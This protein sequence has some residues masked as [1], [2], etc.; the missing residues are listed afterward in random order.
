VVKRAARVPRCRF[1]TGAFVLLALSTLP[2]VAAADEP[3]R[4]GKPALLRGR[5]TRHAEGVEGA[6]VHVYRSFD[7][8]LSHSP[9]AASAPTDGDGNYS[10]QL[11]AGTCYLVAK[12]GGGGKDGPLPAGG[13]YSFH[14]SN[15][16]TLAAGE[17]RAAD[18]SLARKGS[19]AVV[20]GSDDPGSGTLAGKV[21]YRGEGMAGVLVRLYL[22]GGSDFRGMGYAAAPP[23]GEDGSFRFD[24]LPES[25]YFLLARKRAG[26]RG[27][28]PL[29]EGDFFGYHIDNPVMVRGG[30]M[31]EVELEVTSKG[32][33]VSG[34]DSRPRPTG[35]S[36]SGRIL[37][38]KGSVVEGVYA[39]AYREKVMA[40]KKPA[41]IS[42]PVDGHG[43]FVIYLSGGGTYYIGARSAYGDSP[44]KGE[45]YGRYDETAD[46]SVTVKTGA[47]LD[48]VDI[49]V[50]RILP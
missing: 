25:D 45:W 41:F 19:D 4:E 29:A 21:T 39:F 5:V 26:G 31:T 37:D 18:F 44:A 15:P 28:G 23:T 13:L 10:V 8:L 27:A 9:L 46:H 48:G 11:P 33:E 34:A 40:H 30:T 49:V 38:A 22:D 43:R 16:F 47:A 6:R 17:E 1:L 7:D 42:S 2:S 20:S 35:T 50:E 12:R 3:G 32:R 24:Y 36:I 14:G